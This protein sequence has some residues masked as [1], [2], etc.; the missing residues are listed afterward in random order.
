MR[1]KVLRFC[2][3]RSGSLREWTM[4]YRKMRLRQMNRKLR[5]R[6][7]VELRSGAELFSVLLPSD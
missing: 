5:Q 1:T 2:T 7:R 4:G 6:A 3:S